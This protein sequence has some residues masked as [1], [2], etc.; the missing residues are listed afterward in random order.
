MVRL[1]LASA[2]LTAVILAGCGAEALVLA[3]LGF[4]APIGGDF[5]EDA[6]PSTVAL[7]QTGRVINIQIGDTWDQ[8]YD[9]KFGVTG[10][11]DLDSLAAC[12][13]FTGEVKERTLTAYPKGKPDTRCFTAEFENE[14]VLLLNDGTRLMRNFPV[15]LTT[16]VWVNINN[17]DQL[18]KFESLIDTSFTGCE[19][20]KG[21]KTPL[22]G[23]LTLP[24]IDAGIFATIDSLMVQRPHGGELFSGS[25][26]GAS[27]IRLNSG[28]D[29]LRL[30]RREIIASCQQS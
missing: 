27:G 9:S 15:D 29:E 17:E 26:H 30:E 11:T 28:Q 5:N 6:D 4:I 20:F 10:T 2:M 25:F 23:L 16:G 12:A 14:S 13:S 22:A 19:I 8:F 24:N 3:N 1:D 7:E 18:F 21:E